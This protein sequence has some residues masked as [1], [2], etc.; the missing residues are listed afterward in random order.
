MKKSDIVA[1][2]SLLGVVAILWWAKKE[3][4]KSA[5]M[6]GIYMNKIPGKKRMLMTWG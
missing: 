5:N 2:V 1:G 6:G 3:G 4:T